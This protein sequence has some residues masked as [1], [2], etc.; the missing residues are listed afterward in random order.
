MSARP[1]AEPP[2]DTWVQDLGDELLDVVGPST[3]E[4]PARRALAGEPSPVRTRREEREPEPDPFPTVRILEGEPPSPPEMLVRDLLIDRDNNLWT[5]HGGH[6]KSVT[7]AAAIVGIALDYPV[8]GTLTVGRAGPVVIRTGED[9][10]GVQRMLFDAIQEGLGLGPAARA[11]LR[12]RLIYIPDDVPTDLTRDARRL[13]R[14]VRDAEA[15]LLYADPL[16]NLLGGA[17]ENDNDVAAAVQASLR[18]AVCWDA[19]AAVLLVHHNRK[20]GKD[21]AGGGAPSVHDMRGGG[22]WANGARAVFSVAKKESRI[23]LTSVKANRLRAGVKHE[24]ELTIESDPDNPAAWYSC[25]ITDANAGASSDAL[26]PGKGRALNGNETSTLRAIDDRHEPGRRWSWSAWRD[27]CGLNPNTWKSVKERLID[28]GLA[29]AIRTGKLQ[30]N[31]SPEYVYAIT[32]DGRRA[33]E[34][35]WV[36]ERASNGEG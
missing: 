23:T 36:I 15:V 17:N 12:E 33:L 9:G 27:D 13:A 7:A 31:G 8:F 29:T 26:V 11:I 18:R 32:P 10:Q 34:S 6:G 25:R 24:L 21:D 22:A 28:A 35:G 4:R 14:T 19:D 3:A 20:P 30:R 2:D 1:A 16:P 5:G